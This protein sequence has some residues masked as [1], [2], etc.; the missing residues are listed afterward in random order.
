V[1]T[2]FV[3]ILGIA[4]SYCARAPDYLNAMQIPLRRGRFSTEHDNTSTAPVVV[5]DDILA[6]DLFPDQ[7]P[8]GRQMSLLVLGP[9]QIV[10]VAGHVKHWGLDSDDTNRIRD[11]VY[12]PVSQVPDKFMTDATTGLDLV[13]R[14]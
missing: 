9:V 10:G 5:I 3:L 7:D 13:V 6:R 11:R 2:I 12:F 14:T 4:F 1:A 8:V